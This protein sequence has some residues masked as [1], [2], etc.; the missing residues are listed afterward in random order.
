MINTGGKYESVPNAGFVMMFGFAQAKM[1]EVLFCE[2]EGRPIRINEVISSADIIVCVGAS[3]SEPHTSGTAFRMRVC[4]FAYLFGLTTY[5]IFQMDVFKHF[6]K[7]E[8]TCTCSR[9][10][11]IESEGRVQ[12]WHEG[13]QR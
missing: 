3:L 13:E 4:M 6:A 9:E 10:C 8:C 1:M 11:E 12:C 7:I 5:H 2:Y